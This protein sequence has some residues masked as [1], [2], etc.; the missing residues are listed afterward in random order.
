MLEVSNASLA[1]LEF[2]LELLL[3]AYGFLVHALPI[4]GDSVGIELV[5]QVETDRTGL[6]CH[7]G[8]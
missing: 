1:G 6:L 3:A 5:G 4:G 7:R 8:S 2:L